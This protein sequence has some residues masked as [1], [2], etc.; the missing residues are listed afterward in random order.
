MSQDTKNIL[1]ALGE[2]SNTETSVGLELRLSFSELVLRKLRDKQ[3]SQPDLADATGLKESFLS[4][5]VNSEANC[6]FDTAGKLLFAFGIL[7]PKIQPAEIDVIPV[8]TGIKQL[9]LI[10]TF[11]SGKEIKTRKASTGTEIATEISYG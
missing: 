5:V 2:F 9:K 6:T 1:S 10:G 4:R 11:T 8:S 3:W 7:K